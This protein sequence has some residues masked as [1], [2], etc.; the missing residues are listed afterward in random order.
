MCGAVLECRDESIQIGTKYGGSRDN[1]VRTSAAVT[2][3]GPMNP[4]DS[5]A[6]KKIIAS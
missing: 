4:L 1:N 5:W 2:R 3:I 6:I